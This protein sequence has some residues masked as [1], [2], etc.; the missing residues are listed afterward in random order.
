MGQQGVRCTCFQREGRRVAN[1]DPEIQ[2][3]DGLVVKFESGMTFVGTSGV[4][5]GKRTL[6]VRIWRKFT[7]HSRR[8][9]GKHLE[10]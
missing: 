4:P 6:H 9:C 1:Q 2:Q 5:V 3:A 8:D 7:G 10:A